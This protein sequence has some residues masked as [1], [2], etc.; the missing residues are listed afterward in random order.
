[1]D[2]VAPLVVGYA[3]LTAAGLYLFVRVVLGTVTDT[4][5]ECESD[6]DF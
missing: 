6:T 2:A 4:L 1:M 5:P 3:L